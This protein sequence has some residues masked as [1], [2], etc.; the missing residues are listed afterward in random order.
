[1]VDLHRKQDH[2]NQL[3]DANQQLSKE[4]LA[5]Y[6]IVDRLHNDTAY[7]EDVARKELG[8]VR[9]DELIFTFASDMEL[10]QP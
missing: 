9:G 3:I 1:M 7:I 2:L 8:M 5:M 6:R 10:R 4:N